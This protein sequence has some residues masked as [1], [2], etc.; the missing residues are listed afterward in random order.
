MLKLSSV[1]YFRIWRL[2]LVLAWQ[3]KSPSS[4]SGWACFHQAH[5]ALSSHRGPKENMRFETVADRRIKSRRERKSIPYCLRGSNHSNR[6]HV[7]QKK[8]TWPHYIEED[9]QVKMF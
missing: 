8:Y 5:L 2:H 9:C 7:N 6:K 3:Q 4:A 1:L